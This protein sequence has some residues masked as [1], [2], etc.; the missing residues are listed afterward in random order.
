MIADTGACRTC[1][2]ETFLTL[3]G[4][5]Y[6]LLQSFQQHIYPTK[7]LFDAYDTNT[8]QI[9]AMIITSTFCLVAIVF[10]MYDQMVDSRNQKILGNAA[11]TNAIVKQIFP[12]KFR[13]RLLNQQQV[14]KELA[15]GGG[16]SKQPPRVSRPSSR[17]TRSIRA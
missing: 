15:A 7:Q 3:S 5:L 12:G 4:S 11:R 2:S 16:R 14:E 6:L 17:V 8:P 10:F 13:E 9:F 1:L